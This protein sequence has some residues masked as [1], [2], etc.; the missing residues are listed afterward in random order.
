M[1]YGRSNTGNNAYC[2]ASRRPLAVRLVLIA[3]L[4]TAMVAVLVGCGGRAEKTEI[5]SVALTSQSVRRGKPVI[6]IRATLAGDYVESGIGPIYL[7]EVRP[8]DTAVTSGSLG[9]LEPIATH[10]LKYG[11]IV[12]SLPLY[13]AHASR[14]TSAF[15]IAEKGE[16]G[17]YIPL[18]ELCYLSNPELLA[19][20]D[21]AHPFDSTEQGSLK[22][23][24]LSESNL[25]DAIELGIRHTVLD[26]S[27]TSL[28]LPDGKESK[29]SHTYCGTTSFFNDYAIARLDALVR[30]YEN[31]GISVI[32]RLG[33]FESPTEVDASLRC[34]YY[35][36][37]DTDGVS[38]YAIR[39]ADHVASA[40]LCALF[41]FLGYRYC[42]SS[43]DNRIDSFIIGNGVNDGAV[44][45]HSYGTDTDVLVKG[46][47][48]LL[49][50]AYASLSAHYSNVKIYISLNSDWDNPS[51]LP[52]GSLSGR[53]FLEGIATLSKSG[54][55][56]P[57]C[58]ALRTEVDSS[59]FI[60][61]SGGVDV[62]AMLGYESD[63][64]RLSLADISDA[65]SYL[66]GNQLM[67]NATEQRSIIIDGAAVTFNRVF[68]EA[69]Q[70]QATLLA[71]CY[72]KACAQTQMDAFIYSSLYDTD[73]TACG[74]C[75]DGVRRLAYDVYTRIDSKVGDGMPDGIYASFG[76]E[77]NAIY[78]KAREN[79][80]T[81]DRTL[82]SGHPIEVDRENNDYA[83]TVLKDYE[84]GESLGSEALFGETSS[85]KLTEAGDGV[86]LCISYVTTPDTS[87]GVVIRSIDP[88][89]LR[90][91]E[92]LALVLQCDTGYGDTVVRLRL[93][94]EGHS[95]VAEAKIKTF[96]YGSVMFEIN[97]FVDGLGDGEITAYI[98]VSP[99]DLT[100]E[101]ASL[102][103]GAVLYL[104]SVCS[105]DII[106][107]NGS[108]IGIVF[109][110]VIIILVLIV[111]IIEIIRQTLRLSRSR[112]RRR[113][114]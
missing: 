86:S 35:G 26:V 50:V 112:G 82:T 4:L 74:L 1:N 21:A 107:R 94:Q 111:L 67:Y 84:D 22:G 101:N 85:L 46:Y 48:E 68:A 20:A 77:F 19:S 80:L 58:V 25:S 56:F 79:G 69:E 40:K 114:G 45:Y 113:D 24:A 17:R 47:H 104:D 8:S 99:A 78:E 59:L 11:E 39:T 72:V 43:A 38:G 95:Y 3:M 75:G 93:E 14:L 90:K 5:L 31:A 18:T 7:F 81:G 52:S 13:D 10:K 96:T 73:L 42:S 36:T 34:L 61:E 28:L 16:D 109:V 103:S 32:L 66:S 108:D 57:W 64:R 12:F 105:V 87:C 51:E 100:P 62:G 53:A 89:S 91:R 49:R 92:A 83:L 70:L 76:E 33:L 55:D 65:I 110:V 98:T 97:E 30:A 6:E 37:E 88:A 27:I 63:G 15:V 71:Y 9:E 23:L 2:T 102:L 60:S 106:A 41:D 29:T 54:G 44:S